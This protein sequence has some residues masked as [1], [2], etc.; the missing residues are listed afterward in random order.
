M[1]GENFQL[2]HNNVTKKTKLTIDENVSLTGLNNEQ[3]KKFDF[4]THLASSSVPRTIAS[5]KRVGEQH[6]NKKRLSQEKIPPS[7]EQTY[8]WEVNYINND[9]NANKNTQEKVFEEID[10][11]KSLGKSS[12]LQIK[13][14]PKHKYPP[15]S[16]LSKPNTAAEKSKS[17]S[18]L[19][20]AFN[21]IE[22]IEKEEKKLNLK[23]NLQQKIRL[24]MEIKEKSIDKLNLEGISTSVN[25]SS[26][27]L[28][29][30]GSNT[31]D[32]ASL[33]QNIMHS[34]NTINARIDLLFKDEQAEY[35]KNL[36]NFDIHHQN[37]SNIA[38]SNSDT[39]MQDFQ[40][41]RMS[42]YISEPSFSQTSAISLS[43]IE[44]NN[45][46][47]QHP[48]MLTLNNSLS[49][50]PNL[51]SLPLN[52]QSQANG[53]PFNDGQNASVHLPDQHFLNHFLGGDVTANVNISNFSDIGNEI[54]HVME[55]GLNKPIGTKFFFGGK[56]YSFKELLPGLLD[57]QI[58]DT[59]PNKLSLT[60]NTNNGSN[61]ND[62]KYL[63][64]ILH[65]DVMMSPTVEH[66]NEHENFFKLLNSSDKSSS[67]SSLDDYHILKG[68]FGQ[69]S[70][71]I[72]PQIKGIN[73]D[74][75]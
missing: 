55:V 37:Q 27:D 73:M 23:L 14:K 54:Q 49:P 28:T 51:F 32:K 26:N 5:S 50:L 29:L 13:S 60:I 18:P 34:P 70:S 64:L 40:R 24:K 38:K 16:F 10:S 67:S 63:S 57:D 7:T 53:Y 39:G 44:T 31:A 33:K 72:F 66:K 15:R 3:N 62:N 19:G 74:L 1:K 58:M 43:L 71:D 9:F 21:S 59:N 75:K 12:Q 56:S 35:D 45:S 69:S 61:E 30:G 11:R 65:D 8:V 2:D 68:D 47:I 22:L 20:V 48:Q 46:N 17:I 36:F 6:P 4:H 25:C 42:M 41:N 52:L